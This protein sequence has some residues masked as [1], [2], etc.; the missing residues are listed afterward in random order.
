[1]VV[2]RPDE[3]PVNQ[4]V[5]K[6][7]DDP[8]RGRTRGQSGMRGQSGRTRHRYPGGSTIRSRGKG[9][10]I[11][12]RYKMAKGRNRG[13]GHALL[14]SGGNPPGGS[15]MYPAG[16]PLSPQGAPGVYDAL[17]PP[18][19]DDL[20]DD[21]DYKNSIGEKHY[22]PPRVQNTYMNADQGASPDGA[23]ATLNTGSRHFGLL[24]LTLLFVP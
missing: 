13:Q 18:D 19:L 21:L 1:M 12:P 14:P 22:F 6:E 10:K 11:I 5:R 24:I 20:D 4:E 15:E 2:T 16:T 23:G 17:P 3:D 7:G 9:A 8:E